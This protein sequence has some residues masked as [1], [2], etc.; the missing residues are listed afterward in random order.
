[1]SIVE[2]LVGVRTNR[3]IGRPARTI[4]AVLGLSIPPSVKIGNG[5]K[6]PHGAFGLVVHQD[7][8]LAQDVTLYQNVT[9]GRS[10][11]HLASDES[12]PGGHIELG[13]GVI[14][15]AGA[16]VLFRS[17]SILKIGSGAM[18]GANSVVIHDIPAGEI[19]AGNPARKLSSLAAL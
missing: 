13:R 7:S 9:L 1:M 2:R 18:V 5:L 17:G 19:W 12:A 14:V 8:V 3:F 11:V 6:L 10:D 4:L 16:V 15:G